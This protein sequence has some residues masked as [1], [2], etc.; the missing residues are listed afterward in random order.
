MDTILLIFLMLTTT[1]CKLFSHSLIA[2]FLKS[3]VTFVHHRLSHSYCQF[4]SQG[5]GLWFPFSCLR[6]WFCWFRSCL[7]C[8]LESR[9]TSPPDFSLSCEVDWEICVHDLGVLT[10]LFGVH[11]LCRP[12]NCQAAEDYFGVPIS[13]LVTL[14]L[15]KNVIH[16]L[17]RRAFWFYWLGI[18]TRAFLCLRYKGLGI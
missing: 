14:T 7:T 13:T 11:V 9:Q 12:H 10:D 3:I 15:S 5:W 8:S 16:F 4:A 6:K 17:Y 2:C 18:N 1:I